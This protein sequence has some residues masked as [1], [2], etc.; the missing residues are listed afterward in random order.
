MA[1]GFKDI[2]VPAVKE[3]AGYETIFEKVKA[4]ANG[5]VKNYL[6]Y[7]NAVRKYAIRIND[8]PERLIRDEI[9]DRMGSEEQEDDNQLRRYA[10]SGHMYIFEYKAKTAKKLPYYDEFPLVYVI[11]ATR[12]E[13]WGLNLHYLTPKRRAWV[14]KRLMEGRI[15][16]PRNC[17]HKYITSHVDGYLLDLAA[18]EW[19]SAILLPIETFVRSNK[20]ISG[21]QSYPKEVVWDETNENFYDKIKQRRIIHGYGIKSDK[22]MVK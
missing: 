22:D 16:A 11:K 6:W 2:Q 21:Q 13:F 1:Q 12:H 18:A 7:R 4:E 19:A 5:E 3:D 8:N 10:V 9:Q 15:D 17:F 14:V 20:G